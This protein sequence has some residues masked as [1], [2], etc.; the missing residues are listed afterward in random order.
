[1]KSHYTILA[2]I[3]QLVFIDIHFSGD[4]KLLHLEMLHITDSAAVVRWDYY[5]TED[6]RTL[7]GFVIYTRPTYVMSVTYI[8]FQLF[9]F[10]N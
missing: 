2:F 10:P 7:L 5:R 3:F 8:T 9:P 4:I 6:P 1:M